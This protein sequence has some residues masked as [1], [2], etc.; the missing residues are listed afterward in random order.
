[1][2]FADTLTLGPP[3]LGWRAFNGYSAEGYQLKYQFKTN[4]SR[5]FHLI[6]ALFDLG[7]YTAD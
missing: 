5:H 7:R 6:F 4:L 2:F 1:M 3:N